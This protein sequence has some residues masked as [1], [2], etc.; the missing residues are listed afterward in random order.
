MLWV[1]IPVGDVK[2]DGPMKAPASYRELDHKDPPQVMWPYFSGG[3]I[4]PNGVAE[5]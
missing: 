2:E 3:G 4:I 5:T 1:F